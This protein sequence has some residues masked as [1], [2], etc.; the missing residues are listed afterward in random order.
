MTY[1]S[2]YALSPLPFWGRGESISFF[3]TV[4]S[5]GERGGDLRSVHKGG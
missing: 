1:S 5:L 3:V 2:A 4:L